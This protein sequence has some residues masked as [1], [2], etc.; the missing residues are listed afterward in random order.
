ML[1]PLSSIDAFGGNCHTAATAAVIVVYYKSWWR[2]GIHPVDLSWG[3]YVEV[4]GHKQ[5]ILQ[6]CRCGLLE[7][8]KVFRIQGK[9]RAIL[10]RQEVQFMI[11][12]L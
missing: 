9:F 11:S 7:D 10:P 6:Q 3:K 2:V 4:E 1:V 5:H 12:L 8:Q